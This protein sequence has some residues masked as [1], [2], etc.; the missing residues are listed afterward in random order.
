MY[1]IYDRILIT[2]SSNSILLFKIDEEKGKWVI[3]DKY[4][5]IRGSIYFIKGN[6]RF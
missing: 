4:E 6:K 5:D 2:R 3:Y 1:L